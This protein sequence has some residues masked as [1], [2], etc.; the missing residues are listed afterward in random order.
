M[1]P[2]NN[3]Y[4]LIRQYHNR[5]RIREFLM[6]TIELYNFCVTKANINL[7]MYNKISHSIWYLVSTFNAK[8]LFHWSI[9]I[10]LWGR[11][12][13]HSNLLPWYICQFEIRYFSIHNWQFSER[14]WA[15][16]GVIHGLQNCFNFLLPQD[17]DDDDMTVA[18]KLKCIVLI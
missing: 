2:H 17:D 12:I 11:I 14:F 1:F 4:F 8:N 18:F 3:I 7:S 15:F 16:T 9:G 13:F 6:T 10:I 5:Y